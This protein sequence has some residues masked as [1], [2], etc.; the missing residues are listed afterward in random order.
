MARR[1]DGER[2][3][4]CCEISSTQEEAEKRLPQS[5]VCTL[6]GGMAERGEGERK[7]LSLLVYEGA[8]ISH[9]DRR[10]LRLLIL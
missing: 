8:H 9:D 7:E 3:K 1:M 10:I 5:S 6:A 4:S 2:A